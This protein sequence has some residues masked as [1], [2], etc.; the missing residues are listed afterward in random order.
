MKKIFFGI[1]LLPLVTL[2]QAGE[3]NIGESRVYYDSSSSTEAGTLYYQ[4]DNLVASEHGGIT[5][6]YENDVV[7]LEAHD[8]DGDGKL[9]AFLELNDDEVT[10]MTGEG[11]S[12]FERPETVEFEELLAEGGSEAATQ[13]DLVGSLDSITI[14]GGGGFPWWII[15]LLAI[16]GG[17]WFYKKRQEKEDKKKE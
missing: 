16:G 8:T 12:V 4:S 11:A 15:L 6:V 14:P 10:S 3:L 5:L 2:A 9:D 17:Y 13:D 1:L 7:V